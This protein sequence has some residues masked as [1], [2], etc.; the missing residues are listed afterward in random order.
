ML[1]ADMPD[2]LERLDFPDPHVWKL[3]MEHNQVVELE[4][5]IAIADA[6]RYFMHLDLAVVVWSWA[7]MHRPRHGDVAP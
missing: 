6:Y 1:L 4:L 2:A 3:V 7:F 5:T